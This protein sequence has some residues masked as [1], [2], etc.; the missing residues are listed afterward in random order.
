MCND[1]VRGDK[2]ATGSNKDKD[3]SATHE[4]L[5]SVTKDSSSGFGSISSVS[6]SGKE[7][8]WRLAFALSSGWTAI[9]F[10]VLILVTFSF[11][12]QTAVISFYCGLW[13][14]IIA[15]AIIRYIEGRQNKP[16]YFK[17]SHMSTLILV[18]LGV[19]FGALF[20]IDLFG[21]DYKSVRFQESWGILKGP[22]Q[23]I[24]PDEVAMDCN[25]IGPDFKGMWDSWYFAISKKRFILCLAVCIIMRAAIYRYAIRKQN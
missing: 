10:I 12:L 15:E 22:Y 20:I 2:V 18:G 21:H 5:V 16:R 9:F 3:N 6:N 4:D 13:L 8:S 14:S 7:L 19:F 17:L 23:T 24:C 25:V 1:S 11:S